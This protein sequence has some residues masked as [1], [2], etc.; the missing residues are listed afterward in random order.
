M[1]HGA[2]PLKPVLQPER[3][4]DTLNCWPR[5][6]K[7][8]HHN[9]NYLNNNFYPSRNF[10]K[11]PWK[12]IQSNPLQPRWFQVMGSPRKGGQCLAVIYSNIVAL[13]TRL[14]SRYVRLTPKS[15]LKSFIDASMS[16]KTLVICAFELACGSFLIGRRR[17]LVIPRNH[18]GLSL[19]GNLEGT[20]C[21]CIRRQ[22][23]S[24]RMWPQNNLKN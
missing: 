9:K 16:H 3:L 22:S 17:N 18:L 8:C 23:I 11:N 5:A 24:W 13:N 15:Y 7:K 2:P 14:F 20:H 12:K 19:K 21:L 4:Q 1:R 10:D 6:I